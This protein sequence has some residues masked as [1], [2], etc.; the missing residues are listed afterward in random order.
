MTEQRPYT[1]TV[2]PYVH[3]ARAGEMLNVGIVLHVAAEHRRAR[4]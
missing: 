3:D 2:L 1:H 4:R